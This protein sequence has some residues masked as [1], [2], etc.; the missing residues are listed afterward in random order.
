[1]LATISRVMAREILD[2]RGNPTLEVDVHL[3]DGAFGRAAVPSGAST[4]RHEAHELRDK[5]A[6]R[7]GGAGV[8]RAV[9]NVQEILGPALRGRSALDQRRIDFQLLELDGTAD[10]HRLGA[11][12]L[13]GVSLAAAKAAAASLDLPLF[14]YLGGVGAH[15]LPLPMFNIL[16]GGR[17]TNWQSTDVQEYLILPTGAVTYSEGL[18][19][20]SEIYQAL[21]QAIAARGLPTSVGDEG[22]FAPPLTTST[23]ALQLLGGVAPASDANT[24]ALD[25]LV[26]AIRRAGYEPGKDVHLGIDVAANELY[27]DGK[28]RLRRDDVTLTTGDLIEIY[29]AWIDR[30]PIISLEDGLAEDDWEG[31]A[32]LNR[33]LGHRV[34]LIGDDIFVTNTARLARGIEL[35][36]ANSILIK[37]NQIGT[38]SET[39]A[40]VELAREAGWTAVVSHRSGETEDTTIA[41]FVVGFN[42]GQIKTGAPARSER[43]AKYNQLL[44]IEEALGYGATY[45]GMDSLYSLKRAQAT[46]LADRQPASV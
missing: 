42:V 26:E 31:W 5:D 9:A 46:S 25:L 17:H 40:A 39:I 1:M 18:R 44:R 19:M 22:G 2:S 41:D 36:V 12:A 10:K 11:N 20:A 33:R 23:D 37:L 13:L 32:L 35:G 14:R 8:R 27:D 30:Y 7:Y 29:E 28:Y 24:E 15:V 16:N 6:G 45:R 4:G 38:L 21:R 3:A 34:Q 43:V